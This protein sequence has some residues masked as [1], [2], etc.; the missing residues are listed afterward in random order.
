MLNGS[1]LPPLI[2]ITMLVSAGCGSS[3][4]TSPVA[5]GPGVTA[6]AAMSQAWSG[7]AV[8]GRA[9]QT[10]G[11]TQSQTRFL[12]HDFIELR[13][14][15][16]GIPPNVEVRTTWLDAKGHVLGG[17]MHRSRIGQQ[18][19]VFASPSPGGLEPGN[20]RVQLRVAG[21]LVRELRFEVQPSA[22]GDPIHPSTSPR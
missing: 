11:K 16:G 4:P 10:S 3:I 20:Y 1:P 12:S 14:D 8:L 6:P 5:A 21:Q 17:E 9:G 19:M 18:A 15:V 7:A 22:P 13:V 2:A